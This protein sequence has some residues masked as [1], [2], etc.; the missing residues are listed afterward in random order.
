MRPASGVDIRVNFFGMIV[1]VGQG[2]VDVGGTKMDKSEESL[3]YS[4]PGDSNSR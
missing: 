4:F 3:R 2:I 1:R